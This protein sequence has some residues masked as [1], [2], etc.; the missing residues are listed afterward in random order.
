MLLRETMHY[1]HYTF[2]NQQNVC[3]Q[4]QY[5]GEVFDPA[6]CGDIA[7]M[8]CDNCNRS[9]NTTIKKVDITQEAKQVINLLINLVDEWNV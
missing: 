4:L 3:S 6:R 5:F 8:R 9:L 1:K 7:N 2:F